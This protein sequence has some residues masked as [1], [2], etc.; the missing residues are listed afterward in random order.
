MKL[1]MYT[2]HIQKVIREYP[3]R[4]IE[5]GKK[6]MLRGKKFKENIIFQMRKRRETEKTMRIT[7]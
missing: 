4:K 1:G 2:K 5:R 3:L 7:N 6:I